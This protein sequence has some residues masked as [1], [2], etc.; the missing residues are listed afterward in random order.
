M[1]KAKRIRDVYIEFEELWI[2][3]TTI[4]EAETTRFVAKTML[5]PEDVDEL[6]KELAKWRIQALEGS[7]R[8][9]EKSL[10]EAEEEAR[11]WKEEIEKEGLTFFRETQLK[12][13]EKEVA[14]TRKVIE[15]NKQLLKVYRQVEKI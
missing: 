15:R 8:Y 11:R 12:D 9:L 6:I 10:R 7:Q 1:T 13:A 5:H 14:D 4:E 3:L 2:S